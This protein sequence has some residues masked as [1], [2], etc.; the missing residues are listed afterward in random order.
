MMERDLECM[1][2]SECSHLAGRYCNDITALSNIVKRYEGISDFEIA[3]DLIENVEVR[4]LCSD[5]SYYNI[6]STCVK[7][8]K[9]NTILSEWY[10]IAKAST[11]K[12]AIEKHRKYHGGLIEDYVWRINHN[13][14]I[15]NLLLRIDMNWKYHHMMVD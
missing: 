3:N 9:R 7:C 12:E 8:K 15:N 4:Y 14:K 10:D 2:L 11:L 5:C 6:D 13:N 1:K